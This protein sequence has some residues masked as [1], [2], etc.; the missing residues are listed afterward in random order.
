MP[1]QT[2]FRA[3]QRTAPPTRAI[4]E[5]EEREQIKAE[6]VDLKRRV[7]ALEEASAAAGFQGAK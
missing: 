6:Q 4:K 7:E 3:H 2:E 1:V 5:R